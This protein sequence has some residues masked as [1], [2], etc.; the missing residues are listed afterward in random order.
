[1]KIGLI[2][3]FIASVLT[4]SNADI[5]IEEDYDHHSAQFHWHGFYQ[6]DIKLEHHDNNSTSAFERRL[7]SDQLRKWD[8]NLQG[9]YFKVNVYIDQGYTANQAYLIEEAFK[10]FKYTAKVIKWQFITS[11][12][13][14][15]NSKPYIHIKK[16]GGC[17]SYYG[18]TTNA[19]QG[20][21]LSL[22]NACLSQRTIHHVLLHA[23]G[24]GHEVNRADRDSYLQINWDNIDSNC[25]QEFSKM[26]DINPLG[27]PFDY[28][29][30]MLYNPR[31]CAKS[32]STMVSKTN[33]AIDTSKNE[34]SWFDYVQVRLMYQCV[35]NG[36]SFNRQYSDYQQQKCSSDCKCWKNAGGCQGRDDWCKGDLICDVNWCKNEWERGI[37]N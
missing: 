2:I 21:T 25:V 10:K 11:K 14:S 19:H 28:K 4:L 35:R 1:M 27:M 6:G 20:Q 34:A 30:S 5:S 36:K 9:D 7:N 17:W 16:A 33:K 13:G 12:P 18:R 24:F 8:H 3:S 29:S 15:S 37:W 22:D 23:M 32:G 26:K 31:T